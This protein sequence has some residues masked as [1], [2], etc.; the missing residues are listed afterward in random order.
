MLGPNQ[1]AN[2]EIGGQPIEH[3]AAVGMV[4]TLTVAG[5]ETTVNGIGSA[6]WLIGSHLQIKQ[7][8]IDNP[9]LIPAAVEEALRLE[10]LIQMMARTVTGTSTSTA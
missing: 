2:A 9:R 3:L 10:S 6:L 7:R 4:L 5:H 8:L 1:H